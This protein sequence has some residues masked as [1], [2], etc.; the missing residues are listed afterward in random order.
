[1]SDPSNDS[2]EKK[3]ALEMNSSQPDVNSLKVKLSEVPIVL[4]LSTEKSTE[5]YNCLRDMELLHEIVVNEKYELQ[6]FQPPENSLHKQVHTIFHNIFW[7]SIDEQLNATPPV[8]TSAIHIIETIRGMIL[9]L[10]LPWQHKLQQLFCEVL[11]MELIKQK[12]ERNAFDLHYYE[13]YIITM[14]EKICAPI[15]DDDV[16]RLRQIHEV[17]PLFRA[18]VSTLELM[19]LDLANFSIQ[20]ARPY[21]QHH[22][23]TLEQRNFKKLQQYYNENDIDLLKRTKLWLQ[24]NDD[25]LCQLS[26]CEQNGVSADG[27]TAATATEKSTGFL[28]PLDGPP[29]ST[30][31]LN[32]AYLELVNWEDLQPYPETIVLDE[33]RYQSLQKEFHLLSLVSAMLLVTYNTIGSSITGVTQLRDNLKKCLFILLGKAF[34]ETQPNLSDIAIKCAEQVNSVINDWLKNHEFPELT[35]DKQKLLLGQFQDVVSPQHAVHNLMLK[36]TN[37]FIYQCI[38]CGSVDKVKVP[39]SVAAVETELITAAKVFLRLIGL[40]FGVYREFYTELL[41][42]MMENKNKSTSKTQDTS[43]AA[44]SKDQSMNS[45]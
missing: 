16:A 37:E 18:I 35:T 42:V 30:N 11:D 39:S 8:Y 7:N 10:M 2:K 21:M 6:K 34:C 23:I 44:K 26:K 40:N 24:R 15:R 29:T 13:D 17:V 27:A 5:I 38:C 25:K 12:I 22:Y 28:P 4:D 19:K 33:R 41:T 9:D 32:M 31:I 14:M 43:E 36:R 3:A 45:S 1:M 20:Q